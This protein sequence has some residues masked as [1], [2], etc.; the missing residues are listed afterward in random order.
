[1]PIRDAHLAKSA[2]D[3]DFKVFVSL[4][5]NL[6]HSSVRNDRL[7]RVLDASS[8]TLSWAVAFAHMFPEA[9]VVPLGI[10]NVDNNYSL[11]A[12][13][14]IAQGSRDNLPFPNDYFDLVYS[15]TSFVLIPESQLG[16]IL[17][18]FKRVTK[19]GECLQLYEPYLLAQRCGPV[20]ATFRECN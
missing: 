11:P 2:R 6:V 15:C 3:L 1:M 9:E 17:D 16:Q 10:E 7:L 19:P 13:V 12:N 5:Q 8:N 20:T 4:F 14:T 18:E